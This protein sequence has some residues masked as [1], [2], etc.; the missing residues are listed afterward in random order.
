MNIKNFNFNLKKILKNLNYNNIAESFIKI[1][2]SIFL[3]IITY[4]LANYLSK[5]I[6][7]INIDKIRDEKQNKENRDSLL[8]VIGNIVK[9]FIYFIG[10]YII[11]SFLG[12]N[13]SLI[14]AAFATCGL[15]IA[16]G[17]QGTISNISAGILISITGKYKIGDTIETNVDKGLGINNSIVGKIINYDIL[18]MDLKEINTGLLYRIPNELIWNSVVSKYNYFDDKIYITVKI[19]ISENN[20]LNKVK[21]IVRDICLKDKNIIK[22]NSWPSPFINFINNENKCAV[23]ILLKFLTY[24]DKYPNIEDTIQTDVI[25]KLK[26][27]NIKFV[28]C[29]KL[30]SSNSN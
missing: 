14:L 1:I 3:L 16:L 5:K 7:N 2:V 29:S 20:D 12:F 22:E 11:I 26:E 13:T 30:L 8:I 23:T 17:L 9:N 18:T 21:E 6:N 15:G 4:V 24:V 28:N 10:I 19:I 27:N 25:L